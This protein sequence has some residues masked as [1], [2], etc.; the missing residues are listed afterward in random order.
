MAQAHAVSCH[1]RA[2]GLSGKGA[3]QGLQAVKPHA[4]TAWEHA[5][6]AHITVRTKLVGAYAS[7]K[8]HAK[9]AWKEA[10]PTAKA[11]LVRTQVPVPPQLAAWPAHCADPASLLT[12]D[13]VC[14]QVFLSNVHKGYKKH[15]VPQLQNAWQVP[16]AFLQKLLVHPQ[17]G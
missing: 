9:D 1:R 10:G 13:P 14:V 12:Q 16:K 15:M 7:A 2:F 6:R 3:A 8:E 5:G 17:V 11:V 4:A